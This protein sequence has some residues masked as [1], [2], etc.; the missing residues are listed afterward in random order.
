MIKITY[1]DVPYREKD[2]A[3]K[4]G[5]RWNPQARKWYI[6]S[7]HDLAKFDR[8]MPHNP[9]TAETP[10]YNKNHGKQSSQKSLDNVLEHLEFFEACPIVDHPVLGECRLVG[11]NPFYWVEN[12]H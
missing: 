8:W 11:K 12:S 4:R 3:K 5:A 1:I 2:L 10:F 6:T 9:E 7:N